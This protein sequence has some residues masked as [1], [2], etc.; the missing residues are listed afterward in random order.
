MHNN[1]N[2]LEMIKSDPYLGVAT[3]GSMGWQIDNFAH[4][5]IYKRLKEI[6]FKTDDYERWEATIICSALMAALCHESSEEDPYEMDMELATDNTEMLLHGMLHPDNLATII[7][8]EQGWKLVTTH[9]RMNDI[10]AGYMVTNKSVKGISRRH[11]NDLEID[12]EHTHIVV[13]QDVSL[14]ESLVPE[15]SLDD[16]HVVISSKYDDEYE[17]DDEDDYEE[18]YEREKE[19]IES[20][21]DE[22]EYANIWVDYSYD[23]I[24]NLIDLGMDMPKNKLDTLWEKLGI[25]SDEDNDLSKLSGDIGTLPPKSK[26]KSNKVNSEVEKTKGKDILNDKNNPFYVFVNTSLDI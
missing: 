20:D 3:F 16:F 21:Y 14:G 9:D 26:I 23:D 12:S 8:I 13:L 10:I 5:N 11:I 15:F 22:E 24:D 25:N 6:G 17:D 19:I 7:N 2:I 4:E 18:I 1:Q